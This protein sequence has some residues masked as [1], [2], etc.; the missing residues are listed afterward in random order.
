MKKWIYIIIGVTV[1]ICFSWLSYNNSD[2][3]LKRDI[4]RDI[5]YS[6]YY[7]AKSIVKKRNHC[8]EDYP[9][10]TIE[11]RSES[12]IE[13]VV[14]LRKTLLS[15]DNN[16]SFVLDD[17]WFFVWEDLK[18]NE[19]DVSSRVIKYTIAFKNE[20]D[21]EYFYSE[22][23]FYYSLG[24]WEFVPIEEEQFIIKDGNYQTI[25]SRSVWD[26]DY[27]Y[28]CITPEACDAKK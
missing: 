18:I 9:F 26:G 23:L 6:W 14:N 28:F 7:P 19:I 1:I 10:C 8:V 2:R 16:S 11:S 5:L 3:K 12:E 25:K 17:D 22:E 15:L 24:S 4:N 21:N 13:K 27:D 20:K